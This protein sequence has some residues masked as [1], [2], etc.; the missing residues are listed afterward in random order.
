M[1][2]AGECGKAEHSSSQDKSF[3]MGK[4]EVKSFNYAL[5][6]LLEHNWGFNFIGFIAEHSST[7]QLFN[8]YGCGGEG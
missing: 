8:E 4:Q 1:D 2:S 5:T 7:L 6:F 3:K